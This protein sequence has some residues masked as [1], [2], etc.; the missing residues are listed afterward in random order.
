MYA[1]EERQLPAGHMTVDKCN[2][3]LTQYRQFCLLSAVN[4]LHAPGH[5][6]INIGRLLS[7]FRIGIKLFVKPTERSYN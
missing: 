1:C 3:I 6:D 4:C 5:K 2:R 7:L